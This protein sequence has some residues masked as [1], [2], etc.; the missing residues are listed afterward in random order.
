MYGALPTRPRLGLK[1][2][3]NCPISAL[4]DGLIV[5]IFAYLKPNHLRF[6]ADTL[7]ADGTVTSAE[8]GYRCSSDN[9]MRMGELVQYVSI[10]EL[11]QCS[12]VCRQWRRCAQLRALWEEAD[13]SKFRDAVNDDLVLRIAQKAGRR[14]R[15]ARAARTPH[16]VPALGTRADAPRGARPSNALTARCATPR[17][18]RCP[19]ARAPRRRVRVGSRAL[20]AR[21]CARSASTTACASRT[22]PCTTCRPTARSSLSCTSRGALSSQPVRCSI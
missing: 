17:V 12:M 6:T 19:D 22:C 7:R 2:Q 9:S 21:S 11:I 3:P 1:P 8:K 10:V 5:A 4:D 14:V 16:A 13:L 15:A 20:P 18:L